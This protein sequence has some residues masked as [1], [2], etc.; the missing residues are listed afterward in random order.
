[1]PLVL[2]D[3]SRLVASGECDQPATGR[4]VCLARYDLGEED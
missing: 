1:M 3:D 4:D 2:Q